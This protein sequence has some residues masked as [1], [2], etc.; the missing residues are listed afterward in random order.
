MRNRAKAGTVSKALLE[1]AI[2]LLQEAEH[3]CPRTGRG[4]KPKFPNWVIAALVQFAVLHKKSMSAQFRFF[5]DPRRRA[6]FGRDVALNLWPSRS[7]FFRRYQRADRLL[8]TAVGIQGRRAI[9]EGVVDPKLVAVDK[10]LI[11]A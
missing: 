10:S 7:A 4:A 6:L 2:P 9:D 3:Q 8:Q 1:Q 5:N 11:T